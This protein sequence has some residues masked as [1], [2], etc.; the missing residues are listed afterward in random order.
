MSDF[1]VSMALFGVLLAAFFIPW[2]TM[3]ESDQ[4]F[5]ESEMMKTQ[6]ERTAALMITTPGYPSDWQENDS[7]PD[8]PGFSEAQDNV[9]SSEK[10]EAFNSI[11]YEEKRSLLSVQDFSLEFVDSDTGEVLKYDGAG[12][13]STDYMGKGPVAYIVPSSSDTGSLEA[14]E[15]INDSDREWH[16]YFPSEESYGDLSAEKIYTNQGDA[17]SMMEG[18]ISNI[19]SEGYGTVIAENVQV[20]P[21]EVDNSG[22]LEEEVDNGLT[23]VHSSENYNLLVDVF[24]MDVAASSNNPGVVENTE[25]LLS[26]GFEE[27]DTIEFENVPEAFTNVSKTF[28]RSQGGSSCLA[29]RQDYGEGKVY[30]LADMG[31]SGGGLAFSNVSKS[32]ASRGTSGNIFD[33]G[34]DISADAETV[35]T[36]D[37]KV[38]VN[39]SG[40]FENAE[41]DYVVWR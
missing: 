27:G 11:D 25:P 37:R 9:I 35:V 18:L 32:V 12:E 24:G 22:V 8:I 39:R 21:G 14:L 30:F 7:V 19:S 26:S 20:S 38:I 5:S 3:V 1:A 13:S 34:P 4:R 33:Q 31:I 40:K 41:M 6:A 29:C 17:S 28:V 16:F 10:L 2:N 23:Y 36:V 15:T